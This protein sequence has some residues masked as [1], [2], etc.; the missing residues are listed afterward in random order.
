[1]MLVNESQYTRQVATRRSYVIHMYLYTYMH[2]CMCLCMYLCSYK[3]EYE[4]SICDHGCVCVCTLKDVAWGTPGLA[5]Q[6]IR[7]NGRAWNR[8]RPVLDK[9]PHI[10]SLHD[11]YVQHT[12]FFSTNNLQEKYLTFYSDNLKQIETWRDFNSEAFIKS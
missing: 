6:V 11:T 10:Y 1:M 7:T 5:R 8:A 3:T 12:Y 9:I 4:C 2:A